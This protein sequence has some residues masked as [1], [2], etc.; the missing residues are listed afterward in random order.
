[1]DIIIKP[2]ETGDE[3]R[4]KAFVHWKGWQESYRG[5]VDDG[6]LDRMTLAQTEEKAFRW[7]DGILVAKDGARVVGFVGYGPAHGEDGAGEVYA[8][9]VLAEYQ[10][11]GIGYALLRRALDGLAGCRV[12][13]LWAFAEN[14]KALRFYERVGFHPDG[15]EKE[16]VLGAP[17]RGVRLTLAREEACP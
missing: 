14:K 10:H 17:A 13:H 2:M 11:R 12:I 15:T 4:G 16:I 3:I 5:M 7:R 8:L 9:Y 6:Y 1:M